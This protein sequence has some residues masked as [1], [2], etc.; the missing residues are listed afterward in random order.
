MGTQKCGKTLKIKGL[1]LGYLQG[2]EQELQEKEFINLTF[3]MI[4]YARHNQGI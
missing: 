4:F 2:I 1:P 3:L